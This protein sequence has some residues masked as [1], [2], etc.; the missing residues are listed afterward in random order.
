M[1]GPDDS[2][3]GLELPS[4]KMRKAEDKSDLWNEMDIS[5]LDML[6]LKYIPKHL[7]RDDVEEAVE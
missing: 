3:D 5:V 7:R 6:N 1:K 2:G 4:A